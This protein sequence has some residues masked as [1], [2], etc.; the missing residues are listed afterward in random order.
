MPAKF[1]AISS[2]LALPQRSPS[3]NETPR[4]APSPRSGMPT[5]RNALSDLSLSQRSVSPC[6]TQACFCSSSPGS[7]M[8][9]SGTWRN[10][11]DWLDFRGA[12]NS[13]WRRF[14]GRGLFSTGQKQAE[15]IQQGSQE[16]APAAQMRGLG[17][18]S[19]H[20][21]PPESGRSQTAEDRG[22]PPCER[23]L[24]PNLHQ[25]RRNKDQK[26]KVQ[27]R[28]DCNGCLRVVGETFR[29][30]QCPPD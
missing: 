10:A 29:V 16:H 8:P 9:G 7:P 12:G 5:T 2:T 24:G 30:E 11:G 17:F 22:K 23:R 1:P 28:C 26:R 4:T 15:E 21:N 18:T 3:G 20:K 13:D 19:D 27:D 6:R 14:R 25:E